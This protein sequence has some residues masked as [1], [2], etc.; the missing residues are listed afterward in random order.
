MAAVL[1]QYL[2]EAASL[3]FQWGAHD[4]MLFAADWAARLT[5]ADPAAAWRGSYA[6]ADEAAALL[7]RHG[8]PRGIVAC[9]LRDIGGWTQ[10]VQPRAGD[11]CIVQAPTRGGCLAHVAG[12]VA[13]RERV[14]LVTARGLVIAP[15]PIV[16]AWQHG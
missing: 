1:K 15:A 8:G 14:A 13:G 7:E 4:C 16:E 3:R 2:S 9:G 6:S 5:G 12:V 11:I 10:T